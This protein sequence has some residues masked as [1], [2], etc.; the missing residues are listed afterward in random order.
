MIADF[1]RLLF[2][3]LSSLLTPI[4][5]L[6]AVY[7]AYQQFVI[8]KRTYEISSRKL[9]L[10]LYNKRFRVFNE[11]K[12]VLLKIVQDAKIDLIELRNFIFSVNESAFLFEKEITD[13]LEL[14]RKNAIEYN[15]ALDDIEKHPIGSDE[16]LRIIESNRKL[17]DWFLSEYQSIESRFQKYLDFRDL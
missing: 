17:A 10:D 5:A 12:Q 8:N 9:K 4:I 13:Y 7:I 11:T 6:I 15:H 16:K 3:I 2:S 1:Y 14:I